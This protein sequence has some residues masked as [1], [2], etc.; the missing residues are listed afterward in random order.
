MHG[1]SARRATS[2]RSPRRRNI[3]AGRQ[4]SSRGRRCIDW[5]GGVVCN[6]RD[7]DRGSSTSGRAPGAIAVGRGVASHRAPATA[8]AH[9]FQTATGVRTMSAKTRL[10]VA[11][12][13][14]LDAVARHL[15]AVRNRHCECDAVRGRKPGAEDLVA[16]SAGKPRQMRASANVRFARA[17]DRSESCDRRVRERRLRACTHV[18][19]RPGSGPAARTALE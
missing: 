13:T 4:R 1:A 2:R 15:A 11:R 8:S 3:V 14:K 16:Q 10:S 7:L 5:C 17:R 6:V 12:S 18:P 9:C 19:S